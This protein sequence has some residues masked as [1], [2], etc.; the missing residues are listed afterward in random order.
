MLRTDNDGVSYGGF[1][2]PGPGVW[3]TC[4]RWTDE[5]TCEG[6]GFFGQAPGDGYHGYAHRGTRFALCVYEGRTKSIDGNKIAVE[7]ACIVAVESALELMVTLSSGKWCGSLDLRGYGHPL[8]AGLTTV[9]GWLD[10]RGYGHPLPAGLTT[11]DGSLYLG[12]YDHPL[13]AGLW[14]WRLMQEQGTPGFVSADVVQTNKSVPRE[15]S[16]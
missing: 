3:V 11:V 8:P 14:F 13:P 1:V 4:P 10:L 9:G 15:T 2:W 7:R 6:G 16:V 5:R 12:G